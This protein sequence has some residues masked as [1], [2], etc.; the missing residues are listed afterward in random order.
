MNNQET[1]EHIQTLVIKQDNSFL[2]RF[3]PLV[4]RSASWSVEQR[5][6]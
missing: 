6:P 5:R 2:S 4:N 1:C 3:G